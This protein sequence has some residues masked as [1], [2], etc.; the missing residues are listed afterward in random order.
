[1]GREGKEYLWKGLFSIDMFFE[2]VRYLLYV[3]LHG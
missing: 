2:I 1:M 3:I